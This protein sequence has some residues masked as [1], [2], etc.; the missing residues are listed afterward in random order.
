MNRQLNPNEA[1]LQLS[2]EY[3]GMKEIVGDNDNQTIVSWFKDIGFAWVKDDETAWCSCMMNW[4][5]W[6]LNIARSMRLDARSWLKV[7]VKATNPMPGDIVVFWREDRNSWKGHVGLFMGYNNLRTGIYTLG[8]NQNNEVNIT[9]YSV[10]Q[11]LDIRCLN[12][13]T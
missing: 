6:K 1:M 12:Y 8:G 7:G 5:A 11:L 10:T 13:L 2:M 4:I 3:I 9:I